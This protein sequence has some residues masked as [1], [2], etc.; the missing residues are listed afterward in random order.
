MH[1]HRDM[2]ALMSI[3]QPFDHDLAGI[4]DTAG[5]VMVQL[6]VMRHAASGDVPKLRAV[7]R[8]RLQTYVDQVMALADE[9]SSR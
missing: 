9:G 8:D 6:R 7:L 5:S 2:A 4:D 1:Q 3:P